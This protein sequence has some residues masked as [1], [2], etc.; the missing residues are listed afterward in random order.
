MT[1]RLINDLFISIKE[2]KRDESLKIFN[3]IFRNKINKIFQESEERI[4]KYTAPARWAPMISKGTKN[5]MNPK[6]IV[7]C[8]NF[9]NHI[10]GTLVKIVPAGNMD[11]HD[12]SFFHNE[13][14]ECNTYVFVIDKNKRNV[15]DSFFESVVTNTSRITENK[16]PIKLMGND[17]HLNGKVIGSIETDTDGHIVVS[18]PESDKHKKYENLEKMYEDL[19]KEFNVTVTE[20]DVNKGHYHPKHD[21]TCKYG[22]DSYTYRFDKNNKNCKRCVQ[23]KMAEKESTKLP[24]GFSKNS[25]RH[26]K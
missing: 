12:A 1:K 14:A 19:I 17:I 24:K 23:Q 25:W 18:F 7:A 22:A 11:N 5:G 20:S 3:N 15:E 13:P 2:N 9:L 10:P 8:Q 16:N 26:K 21:E 6:D 4:A